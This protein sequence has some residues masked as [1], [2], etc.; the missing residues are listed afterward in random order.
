[1]ADS[2]SF[3]GWTRSP[4]SRLLR[5]LPVIVRGDKRSVGR[6]QLEDGSASGLAIPEPGERWS[7]GAQNDLFGII[8]CNDKAADEH[9]IVCQHFHPSGDVQRL[10]RRGGGRK[11]NHRHCK[12]ANIASLCQGCLWRRRPHSLASSGYR[13]RCRLNPNFHPGERLSMSR[14]HPA[15][16]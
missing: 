3:W 5:V 2:R 7:D 8:T 16:R 4:R 15:H 12:T 1:M 11:S 10:G 13:C 6:V 9:L 14:S